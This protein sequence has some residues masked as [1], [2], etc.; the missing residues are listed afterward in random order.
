MI[1]FRDCIVHPRSGAL[2]RCPLR[3][4]LS[5]F[6]SNRDDTLF[7]LIAYDTFATKRRPRARGYVTDAADSIVL[8]LYNGPVDPSASSS[9]S[10]ST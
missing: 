2:S 10:P 5:L 7:F 1:H 6:L 3:L 9:L 8:L 4:S